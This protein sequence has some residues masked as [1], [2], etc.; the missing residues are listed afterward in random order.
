MKPHIFSDLLPFFL[1]RRFYAYVELYLSIDFFCFVAQSYE[2]RF[3]VYLCHH[4]L[5]ERPMADSINK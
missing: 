5:I 4:L 2:V 3:Y 1:L